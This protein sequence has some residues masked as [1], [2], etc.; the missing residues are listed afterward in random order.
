MFP[1]GHAHSLT[2]AALCHDNT[3]APFSNYG[4]AIDVAAPGV[5]SVS[6]Y[7][8][9]RYAAGSGTSFAAS[10]VAAEAALIRSLAPQ[11][12]ADA[13]RSLIMGIS[14]S[15]NPWNPNYMDQLGKQGAGLID[16]DAAAE[17]L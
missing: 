4:S 14:T 17:N 5:S 12:S 1:A 6:T 10:I 7:W 16:I 9:G 2:V 11:L 3:K 15:V 8:D 13:V